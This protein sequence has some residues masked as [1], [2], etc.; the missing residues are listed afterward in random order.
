MAGLGKALLIAGAVLICL[1]LFLIFSVKMPFV[2]MLPGDIYIKR[3][4]FSFYFPLASCIVISVVISLL[5][6]ILKK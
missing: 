5:L 6:W 4:K 2:G 3:D 1:G